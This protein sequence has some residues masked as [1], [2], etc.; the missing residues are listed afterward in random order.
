MTTRR[1]ML[2]IKVRRFYS[3]FCRCITQISQ[4]MSEAKVE[5]IKVAFPADFMRRLLSQCLGSSAE[6]PGVFGEYG[7]DAA[8]DSIPR[9]LHLQRD[10]RCKKSASAC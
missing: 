7:Q 6:N 2:K 9:D 5:K 10:W 8:T 1:Q 3:L 4:G